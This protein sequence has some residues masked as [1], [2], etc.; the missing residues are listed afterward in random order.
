MTAINGHVAGCQ[1]SQCMPNEITQDEISN[2]GINVGRGV[3]GLLSFRHNWVAPYYDK[4]A[5][6]NTDAES[7]YTYLGQNSQL[8]MDVLVPQINRLLRRTISTTETKS[9]KPTLTG[10]W[11]GK[12]CNC[13]ST[14]S[15][16]KL[17]CQ[18]F[19]FDD[20][21]D[22]KETVKL[23][24]DTQDFNY[25]GVKFTLNNSVSIHGSDTD[26]TNLNTGLWSA[27]WT[28][29]IKSIIDKNNEQDGNINIAITEAKK[30][31][32]LTA[33]TG[34]TL[35][36]STNSNGGTNYKVNSSFGDGTHGDFILAGREVVWTGNAT[37]GTANKP[38]VN[39]TYEVA[40]QTGL[41]GFRTQ[42]S[43]VTSS[44][45]DNITW[46]TVIDEG[47]NLGSQVT[48]SCHIKVNG[49]N[50]TG[51]SR[52]VR[53]LDDGTRSSGNS[54]NFKILQISR[55]VDIPIHL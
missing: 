49:S 6:Y 21:M 27:D 34:I 33:G 5:D 8:F 44:G 51:S 38:F 31:T 55:I 3:E 36:P 46:I 22:I 18:C 10:S 54:E 15:T 41:N 12:P 16:H 48:F 9:V 53:T 19:C 17:G 26:V 40:W 50:W 25:G 23:S 24:N 2:M 30:H 11:T 1:C 28:G 37:S 32:T 43:I 13:G 42:I 7:Y 52:F 35:E 20:V 14:T 29:V 4:R 45:N 47:A 39:G